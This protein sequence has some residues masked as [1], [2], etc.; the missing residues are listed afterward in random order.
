ME[1]GGASSYLDDGLSESKGAA[2]CLFLE[3]AQFEERNAG[4]FKLRECHLR[5]HRADESGR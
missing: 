1:D 4:R 3:L 5:R 2:M